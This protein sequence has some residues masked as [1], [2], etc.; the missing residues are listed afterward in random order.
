MINLKY[1]SPSN[2]RYS[3]RKEKLDGTPKCTVNGIFIYISLTLHIM[4]LVSIFVNKTWSDK[5]KARISKSGKLTFTIS[6]YSKIPIF[7][8]NLLHVGIQFCH[9]TYYLVSVSLILCFQTSIYSFSFYLKNIRRKGHI[10]RP[11][12]RALRLMSGYEHHCE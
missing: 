2:Y 8:E 3:R 6:I 10:G 9:I 5:S 7:V 1:S 11:F 12:S 4:V